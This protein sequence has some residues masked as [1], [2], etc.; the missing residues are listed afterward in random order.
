MLLFNSLF[1]LSLVL[2]TIHSLPFHSSIALL[3]IRFD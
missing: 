2:Q 3:A 1:Y